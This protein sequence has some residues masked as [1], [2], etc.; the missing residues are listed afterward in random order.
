MTP[1]DRRKVVLRRHA[2]LAA[3][4]PGGEAFMQR[5]ANAK[6]NTEAGLA[7][8]VAG[9]MYMQTVDRN[10][11]AFAPLPASHPWRPFADLR[12]QAHLPQ[13]QWIIEHF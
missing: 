11:T 7:L 12:A 5:L 8:L 2:E 3:A 10:C 1:T 6:L 13:L 9:E 4:I